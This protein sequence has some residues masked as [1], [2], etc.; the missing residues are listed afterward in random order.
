MTNKT[1]TIASIV[2]SLAI[3][4]LIVVNFAVQP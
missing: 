3:L 4:G 1:L 2:L